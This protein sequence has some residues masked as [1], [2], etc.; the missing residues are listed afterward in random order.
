MVRESSHHEESANFGESLGFPGPLLR[1]TFL[2]AITYQ[3]VLERIA[4]ALE[5]S[6]NIL[7][8]V[9][10]RIKD[11]PYGQLTVQVLGTALDLERVETAFREQAIHC[12][13]L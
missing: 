4:T 8:G 9:I 12:E 5:V 6:F 1:L 7:E 10:G 3:P 2:G 11:T 13:V